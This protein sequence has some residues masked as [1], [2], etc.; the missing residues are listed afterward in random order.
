MLVTF[1][2]ARCEH[3]TPVRSTQTFPGLALVSDPKNGLKDPRLLWLQKS[4]MDLVFNLP[5]AKFGFSCSVDPSPIPFQN[6]QRGVTFRFF[7][8]ES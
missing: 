6:A 1:S 7:Y 3:P 5:N 2:K 4:K 8:W